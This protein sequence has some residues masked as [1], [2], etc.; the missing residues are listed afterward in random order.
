M[1][2][3]KPMK[4]IVVEDDVNACKNFIDAV[5]RR[6]DVVIVGMT[7]NSNKALE[8]VQAAALAPV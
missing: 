3:E 4:I 6:T 1:S 7:D 5:S 8:F 2:H